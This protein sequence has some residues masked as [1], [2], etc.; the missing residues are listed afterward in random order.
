MKCWIRLRKAEKCSPE[1]VMDSLDHQDGKKRKKKFSLAII[2]PRS[3]GNVLLSFTLTAA[4]F[5]P[6]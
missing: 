2:I 3:E 4:F 5:H 6:C 1:I